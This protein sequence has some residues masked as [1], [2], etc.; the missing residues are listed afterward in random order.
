M[1]AI[2]RRGVHRRIC[3][4]PL[5][6]ARGFNAVHQLKLVIF[7]ECLRQQQEEARTP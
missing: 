5:H 2:T 6:G 4:N 1:L 7:A 3:Y